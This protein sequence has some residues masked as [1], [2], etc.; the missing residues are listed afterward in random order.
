MDQSARPDH[1]RGRRHQFQFKPAQVERSMQAISK[2]V[3]LLEL[4]I[5]ELEERI[6]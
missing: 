1:W 2:D 5:E 6:A 4:N 3:D